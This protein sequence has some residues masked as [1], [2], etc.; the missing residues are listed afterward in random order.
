MKETLDDRLVRLGAEA[1]A[2]E[3]DQADRPIPPHV[4]VSRPNQ[5]RSKVLQ[6]RLSPAEF[7]AIERIAQQR[8]LP[9]STVA[10]EQLLALFKAHESFN[11]DE[12]FNAHESPVAPTLTE[13][14]AQF[15]KATTSLRAVAFSEPHPLAS[16]TS[17]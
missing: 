8:G 13:I 10:R 9:S 15:E 14:V 5:T 2:G 4:K 12:S 16:S 3:A 6:V 17:D 1:E 7:E 11:A